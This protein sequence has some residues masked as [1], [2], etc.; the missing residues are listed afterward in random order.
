ME[1]LE[2][3]DCEDGTC[4]MDVKFEEGEVEWLLNWAV[5]EILKKEIEKKQEDKE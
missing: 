5:N 2:I 3:K 4:D 1:I